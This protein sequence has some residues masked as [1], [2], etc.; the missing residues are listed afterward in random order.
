MSF[1]EDELQSFNTILE[2]RLTAQR[3]EM[4]RIFDQRII[5]SRR[6][7]EQRFFTMQ[8]EILRNMA[9]KLT[10][11]QGRLDS[12]FS[13][14]LQTL[15]TRI[16]QSVNLD[17]EQKNQQVESN[18]ARLLEAQLPGIEQLV[19]KQLQ[20]LTLQSLEDT[21]MTANGVHPLEAFE[22]QTELPWDDLSDMIGKALDERLSALSE[23]LSRSLQNLEQYL[24]VRIHGLRDE[25][26]R[27]QPQS[28]A[29][30]GSQTSVQEVLH[31]IEHLERVVESLQVAMT[32]NHALL[33]NRLY[34]HQQLP[35]ERAHPG[36]HALFAPGN[37]QPNALTMA[38]D[39][40]ARGL[41]PETTGSVKV[42]EHEGL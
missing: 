8:Q 3:K 41:E 38:K 22:V 18:I 28:P 19:N 10:E 33:S 31:G 9:L 42:E 5:D 30:N 24:S 13:E 23:A 40:V 17:V 16:T 29:L 35:L 36:G 7:S 27:S 20:Q 34:H 32:A 12:M 2:Q 39:R 15:Q 26:V 37:G 11:M 4:E 14:K 21:V 1:T 25:F 6:E